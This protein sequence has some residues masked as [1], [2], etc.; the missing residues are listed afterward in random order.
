MTNSCSDVQR[1]EPRANDYLTHCSLHFVTQYG[2]LHKESTIGISKKQSS[3]TLTSRREYFN[4]IFPCWLV[5]RY[6]TGENENRFSLIFLN[7]ADLSNCQ[8]IIF[9]NDFQLNPW[10]H[11]LSGRKCCG[12]I[13]SAGHDLDT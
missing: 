9:K 2:L 1:T 11:I 10:K 8:P 13:L 3:C 4:A 6:V 5:A 12:C 7:F